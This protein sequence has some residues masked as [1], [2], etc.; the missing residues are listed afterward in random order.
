[1][2]RREGKGRERS[3]RAVRLCDRSKYESCRAKRTHR[4]DRIWSWGGHNYIAT[5]VV[6]TIDAASDVIVVL[7]RCCITRVAAPLILHPIVL[8]EVVLI[9]TIF[10][11]FPR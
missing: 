8:L 3:I 10:E 11:L 9:A 7:Q 4:L 5:V 2:T 6:T 1:M